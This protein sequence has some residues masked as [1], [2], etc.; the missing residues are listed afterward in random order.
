MLKQ[1]WFLITSEKVKSETHE[2]CLEKE[3]MERSS[4]VKPSSRWEMWTH[5]YPV[6]RSFS[7]WSERQLF[8]QLHKSCIKC[9]V[10]LLPWPVACLLH[11]IMPILACMWEGKILLDSTTGCRKDQQVHLCSAVYIHLTK[12]GQQKMFKSKCLWDPAR[13][14][15][16]G[17]ESKSWFTVWFHS[18]WWWFFEF[19]VT[20]S[21]SLSKASDLSWLLLDLIPFWCKIPLN[22]LVPYACLFFFQ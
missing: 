11:V 20:Y 9:W 15:F 13:G 17:T 21:C 4:L 8:T 22:N 12:W 1:F 18:C 14:D 16:Q 5:F 3:Q 10:L 2:G 19:T 6:S 7:R